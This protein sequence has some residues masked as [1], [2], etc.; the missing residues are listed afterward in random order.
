MQ[1]AAQGQMTAFLKTQ[2]AG[3]NFLGIFCFTTP[4]H[5]SFCTCKVITGGLHERWI[6]VDV[7]SVGY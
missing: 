6:P 1:A 5:P 3:Q 7:I 2:N 4:A